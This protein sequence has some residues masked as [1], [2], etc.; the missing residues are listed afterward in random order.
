MADV[1]ATRRQVL[2][3]AGLALAVG[4]YSLPFAGGVGAPPWVTVTLIVALC[5]P[6][7][8]RGRHPLPVF[9]A[10]LAA[11]VVQSV[12]G[13]V[14]GMQLL[15]ADVMPAVALYGVA[16]RYRWPVSVG[17]AAAV[18]AWVLVTLGPR[19]AE[20]YLSLGD[21]GLCVALVVIAWT[22]GTT[23][24]LRREQLAQQRRAAAA[25]ERARIA[26]ELHDVVS[27]GLSAVVLLADG[28]AATVHRDPDRAARVMETVRDTGR[29]ALTEMRRMLDV[30]RDDDPG[31]DDDGSPT[32]P[33]P[34]LAQ[35]DRLVEQARATGLPVELT[36]DH[37]RAESPDPPL[38]AGVDLTAYRIVQEALTN[39]RK[40]AGSG[41]RRVTVR[42]AQG[43]DALTVS[44]TDDGDGRGAPAGRIESSSGTSGRGLVGMRERVATCGGTLR[45]GPR[46]GGGYE[47]V[48]HL[49]TP[50]R[51]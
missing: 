13:V 29:N 20:F 21:L 38:P 28:A 16:A 24:R 7:P 32:A 18:V 3:D 23:A 2:L 17:A 6:Y 47:V 37:T 40:H 36:S 33:Q 9:G 1:S 35:L 48:A 39:V 44:V 30:L 26:R 10:I 22:W 42:I 19:L 27:H 34:V 8:W 45:T 11:G 49:P 4:A 41:V 46:E 15:P 5:A 51:D 43:P 50:R 14:G 25:A 31:P 12:L